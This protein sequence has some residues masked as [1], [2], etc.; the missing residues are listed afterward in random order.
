MQDRLD[1]IE[2]YLAQQERMIDD[3]SSELLRLTKKVSK[4]EKQI[5]QIKAEKN[6][7]FVK[8]LSEETPP[9]HY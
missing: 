8:P 3:L 1:T 6:E 9:P 5:D 2:M 4:L 7:T